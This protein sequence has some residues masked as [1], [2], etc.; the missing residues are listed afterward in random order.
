MENIRNYTPE[1]WK[2]T[3]EVPPVFQFLLPLLIVR[4]FS[5]LAFEQVDNL[6]DLLFLLCIFCCDVPQ[7]DAV[8]NKSTVILYGGGAIVAVWLSSIVVGAI[9]SVPLVGDMI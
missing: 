2:F 3:F 5:L 9:N 7:W 8:E 6:D 4:S 1:V